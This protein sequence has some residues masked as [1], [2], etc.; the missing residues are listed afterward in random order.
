MCISCRSASCHPKCPRYD[1]A[2]ESKAPVLDIWGMWRTASLPLFRGPIWLSVVVP[3]QVPSI[4]QI[5][6]FKNYSYSIGLFVKIRKNFFKN[7]LT[8]MYLWTSNKYDSQTSRIWYYSWYIDI[9]LGSINQLIR[10]TNIIFGFILCIAIYMWPMWLLITLLLLMMC[11]F[12]FQIWKLYNITTINPR[13]QWLGQEWKI[14]CVT[15]YLETKPLKTFW[16]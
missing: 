12:L 16:K 9:S 5:D 8:K 13:S 10:S 2:R 6:L 4:R 11:S 3:V 7:N 14:F 15:T 1:T